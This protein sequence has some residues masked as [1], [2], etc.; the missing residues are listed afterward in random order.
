MKGREGSFRL[1]RAWTYTST[2]PQTI[3]RAT[4]PGIGKAIT[5]V[6]GLRKCSGLA[7]LSDTLGWCFRTF[8][9]TDEIRPPHTLSSSSAGPAPVLSAAE[10]N[11]IPPGYVPQRSGVRARTEACPWTARCCCPADTGASSNK[12]F[13]TNSD[14]PLYVPRRLHRIS[15]KKLRGRVL[16]LSVGAGRSGKLRY[17]SWCF[18]RFRGFYC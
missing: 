13:M 7:S 1:A 11:S 16:P 18:F 8:A 15:P 14:Q 4:T 9:S 17:H 6:Y 12:T 2:E 10:L 5:P 3:R